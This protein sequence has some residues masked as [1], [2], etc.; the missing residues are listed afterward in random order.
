MKRFVVLLC[1]ILNISVCSGTQFGYISYSTFNIG[2]DIQALAVKQFLPKDSVAID[3]EFVGEF[4]SD[5]VVN[6][7]INGW[8]MHTKDLYWY[9][10]DVPAPEVS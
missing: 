6:A 2:D 4:S 8:Y 10:P 9:R 5:T 1:L 3:R 7:V